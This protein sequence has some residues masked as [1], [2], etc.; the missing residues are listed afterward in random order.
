[1]EYKIKFHKD[2]NYF[3][4]PGRKK[5]ICFFMEKEQFPTYINCPVYKKDIDNTF[6]FDIPELCPL[7]KECIKICF[8]LT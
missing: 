5:G 4:C 8:D 7:K 1:M 2:T 6:I 3:E